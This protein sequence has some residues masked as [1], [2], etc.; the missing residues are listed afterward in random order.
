MNYSVEFNA[1]LG[2]VFLASLLW[3]AAKL[4]QLNVP[5]VYGRHETGQYK[6]RIPT[7]LSW[8]LME[9]PACLVFA[10]FVFT[11]PLPVTAPVLVLFLMWQ[12][13]YFHRAFIYPFQLQIR[14]GSTTPLRMTLLGAI[15]CTAC[16]YLNGE[17]IANYAVHLQSN[18]WFFTPAFLLGTIL[19]LIGYV[20]NKASD[21][22]LIDLR[23]RKPGEYSIPY[24]GAY[25]WV[26][27]PNYL[28]E[29]IT[30]FGFCCAAWS[31]AGLT[32]A[33][34]TAANLIF[35]AVDNHQWYKEYFPDYPQERKAIIPFIL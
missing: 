12:M 4:L 28:G 10:Y 19:F 1:A 8:V 20:L 7:R 29:I 9:S 14:A 32:F 30:W 5:L 2:F 24:G 21:R 6:F 27:C 17:F 25:R 13:H 18:D 23:K 26:S 11:G 35:R 31:I 3:V 16:G 15:L 33:L 34:M 22:T